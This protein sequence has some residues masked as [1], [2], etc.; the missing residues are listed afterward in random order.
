MP[1]ETSR[2]KL[3]VV[4]P[5]DLSEPI[6]IPGEFSLKKF[7]STQAASLA[8]VETLLTALPQCSIAQAKDFVRLHPNEDAYWSP[9][10]CFVAVPI[11]GQS[12]DTIHLIEEGLARQYLPSAR[13]ARFRLALATKPYDVFFL[14]QVPSRGLDNI[15]NATNAQACE[16]AKT[17]WTQATSRR[18]ENIEG[19]KI[20]AARNPEAFPMPKW[21]TQAFETLL[22]ATYAGR[23]I[24]THDNPAL[25]RLIGAKVL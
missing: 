10:L 20:D 5:T 25:L 15:W 11:K 12:Q 17:L 23:T 19:Y 7:K 4:S 21:P 18:D 22:A 6:P 24:E 3:E 8:G 9:E 14:C 2:P 16:Q 13:I 1:E